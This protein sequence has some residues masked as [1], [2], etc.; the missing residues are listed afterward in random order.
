VSVS[1]QGEQAD[2]SSDFPDITPDGRFVVFDS[3]AENLVAND[4][5]VFRDVFIHNRNTG[6]T[7]RVSVTSSGEQSESDDSSDASVSSDGRFVVFTSFAD[8]LVNSDNNTFV[9]VFIHDRRT[10]KTRRIS[11]KDGAVPD[12]H[13]S[14]PKIS[15]NG[16]FVVFASDAENLTFND[17]NELEDVFIYN[18]RTKKIRLVSLRSNEAQTADDRSYFPTVSRD[19]TRVAFVSSDEDL[20][21]GDDNTEQDVFLRNRKT[22]RTRRLSV[23]SNGDQADSGSSRPTI[24]DNGNVVT[25]ESHSTDLVGND[26]NMQEDIF[27]HV[28]ATHRTRRVSLLSNGDEFEGGG[29]ED[30]VI[31]TNGRFVA[32]ESRAT[33]LPGVHPDSD[34]DVLIHDRRTGR[35]RLLNRDSDGNQGGDG[36]SSDP[37]IS[38]DGRVVAFESLVEDLVPEDDNTFSDIFVR[39][40][41]R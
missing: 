38:G 33:N 28:I 10:G 26:E 30:A 9:D 24:S 13:S 34:E 6:K 31:S 18:R 29:C 25:F 27:V 21:P 16:M 40:P 23:S 11:R 19:G 35:T 2:G 41:L 1:S 8:D 39:A 14:D 37:A 3:G 15:G 32:F 7:R 20:V 5:N 36:D 12:G 22:G 4:N 17:D